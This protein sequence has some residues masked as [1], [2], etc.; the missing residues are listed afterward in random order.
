MRTAIV[1][2]FDRGYFD[3][4]MVFMKSLGINYH[5]DSLDVICLVSEDILSLQNAYAKRINQPNLNI[6]FRTS[7]EFNKFAKDGN[8]WDFNHISKNCS[9]RMFLGSVMPDYDEAIYIDPDT[10]IRRDIQPLLDFPRRNKFLAT[11][12]PVNN[13][14]RC[15]GDKDRPYFNNGVFI[16]DLNYWRDADIEGKMADWTIKNGQTDFPDQNAMNAVLLDVLSP[17]SLNF[18]FFAWMA[19]ANQHTA[20]D[21]TDP[22]IVHF[23]GR[24]KPWLFK[25]KAAFNKFYG[26]WWQYHELL[27]GSRSMEVPLVGT[28]PG[29]SGSS[30]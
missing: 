6:Q 18:N 16:V 21:F 30:E 15:F 10:V 17:F 19:E 2:S 25:H 3:H 9:H 12:E 28:V 14:E 1:T 23:V 5:G 27:T 4:S 13:G 11:L 26:D 24:E 29:T 22:L 8:A 7:S 20:E